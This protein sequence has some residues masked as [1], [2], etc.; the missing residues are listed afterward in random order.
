[1]FHCLNN[2]KESPNPYLKKM[3]DK[4]FKILIILIVSSISIFFLFFRLGHYALWD[5]EAICTLFGKSLWLTGDTNAVLGHNLIAF[6][7]GTELTNLKMRYIPP[8]QFIE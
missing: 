7:F 2:D 8:L 6:N 1:M 5:D 3:S 4:K